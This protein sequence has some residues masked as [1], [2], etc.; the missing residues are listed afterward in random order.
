MTAATTD[1]GFFP[2]RRRAGWEIR[3]RMQSMAASGDECNIV[4]K[5]ILGLSI[6]YKKILALLI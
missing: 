6:T 3:R 2:N 4:N 5:I 1:A